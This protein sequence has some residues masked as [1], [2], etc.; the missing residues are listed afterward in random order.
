MRD[1]ETKREKEVKIEIALKAL[2]EDRLLLEQE[3][4]P[5]HSRT[6]LVSSQFGHA[7][8]ESRLIAV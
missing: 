5:R 7:G 4:S 1:G 6:V 3:R 2:R 8:T